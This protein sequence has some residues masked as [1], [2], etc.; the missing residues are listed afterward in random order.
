M[1]LARIPLHTPESLRAVAEE[2][3]LRQQRWEER[4]RARRER[5]ARIRQ[6][7]H[8][9]YLAS[10]P[11]LKLLKIGMCHDIAR[12]L[13]NLRGSAAWVRLPLRPREQVVLRGSLQLP[14]WAEARAQEEELQTLFAAHLRAG[15]E[16]FEDVPE[17][18]A[19]FQ[20]GRP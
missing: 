11:R 18:R 9:V 15:R 13:T 12:R 4:G 2:R 7:P 5:Q 3:Q 14:N 6:E 1:K 10:I 17:I 19:Y 16:W 20:E 8:H